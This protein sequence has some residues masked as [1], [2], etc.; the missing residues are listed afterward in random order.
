MIICWQLSLTLLL[1]DCRTEIDQYKV[2]EEAVTFGMELKGHLI[3]NIDES[4]L[5]IAVDNAYDV[6]KGKIDLLGTEFMDRKQ[7][8]YSFKIIFEQK[9]IWRERI[10]SAQMTSPLDPH[11][12]HRMIQSCTILA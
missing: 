12:C 7:K 9:P 2:K 5:K 11:I 10:S 4:V 6:S 8:K 1:F 3:S